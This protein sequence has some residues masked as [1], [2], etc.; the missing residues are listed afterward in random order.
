MNPWSLLLII[1]LSMLVGFQIG[2]IVEYRK[3]YNFADV[4][5]DIIEGLETKASAGEK[6]VLARIKKILH[7]GQSHP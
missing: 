6:I 1:P 5:V 4:E 7:I 2:S 3:K